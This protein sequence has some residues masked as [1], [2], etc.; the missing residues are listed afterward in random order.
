MKTTWKGTL[1]VLWNV[2]LMLAILI[3]LPIVKIYEWYMYPNV[4]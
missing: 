2:A 4:A 3:A 1:H